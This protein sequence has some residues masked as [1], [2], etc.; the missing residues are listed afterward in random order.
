M[1]TTP[2]RF[3]LRYGARA[4]HEA[5]NALEENHEDCHAWPAGKVDR[6]LDIPCLS[7]LAVEP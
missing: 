3:V 5:G 7:V 4:V 6:H 2:Y 1:D